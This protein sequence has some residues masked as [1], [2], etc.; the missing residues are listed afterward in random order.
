M[1]DGPEITDDV[2][3]EILGNPDA[4]EA[5]DAL[6]KQEGIE[7]PLVEMPR[8]EQARL[9]A[10]MLQRA[11]AASLGGGDID[12]NEIPDELISAVFADPQG[13]AILREIMQDNQLD[14]EP[15][16]LPDDTKRL[17]IKLL[18]DQGVISFEPPSA[19]DNDAM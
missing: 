7:T 18:V 4:V 19:N 16:D 1:A 14:G 17:I 2:L 5:V 6:A 15:S 9:V 12:A 8:D 10:M 3:N 13:D 11:Q